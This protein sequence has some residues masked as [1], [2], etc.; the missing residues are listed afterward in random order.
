M[1]PLPSRVN[2][3]RVR[4]LAAVAAGLL[5]L[6]LLCGLPAASRAQGPPVVRFSGTQFVVD[7]NTTPGRCG[8]V[9]SHTVGTP[10]LVYFRVE[11]GTATMGQDFTGGTLFASIPAGA[12]VGSAAVAIMNDH[13][14]ETPET[15]RLTLEPSGNSYTVGEP[16][17]VT[18]TILDDD[19]SGPSA[20]FEVAG[21]LPL[22]D[23]GEIVLAAE[24]GTPASADVVVDPLPAGGTTVFYRA[25][26]DNIVHALEFNGTARQ[27]I[28]LPSPPAIAGADHTLNT[29]RIL[30]PGGAAGLRAVAGTQSATIAFHGFLPGGLSLDLVGC[31]AC[32]IA[33]LFNT[34]AGVGC[35][36]LEDVC[37]INCGS[38]TAGALRPASVAAPDVH[39]GILLLRRYRDEV[40]T[41]TPGGTSYRD[42]YASLSPG[43]LA[44]TL[45][46]PT[47][48]MQAI[49]AW[50]LW[51]PAAQAAVDHQGAAFVITPE[52]QDALTA[53]ADGVSAV[54]D[55]GVA[56]DLARIR[57][58]LH[59]DQLAGTTVA[60]LETR[61]EAGDVPVR[62]VGWGEIKLMFR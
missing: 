36:A 13:D 43:L 6:L 16:S 7:E 47:L 50:T 60:A 28:A 59:V 41:T 62:H 53:W 21:N 14:P 56:A 3:R 1:S 20:R 5:F 58:N 39:A 9:L 33:F 55:A 19:S 34:T 23:K 2:P 8:L 46:R 40:L 51:L 32:G 44:A 22:G 54:A 4:P 37:V 38:S 42:L 11:E 29:I 52:M 25:D 27:T 26:Q 31:A 12:L 24:P 49:R 35:S 30:N 61:I 10:L 45:K 15:I 48:L 18:L 57:A 17:S